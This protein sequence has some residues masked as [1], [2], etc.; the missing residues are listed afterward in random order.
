LVMR[1]VRLVLFIFWFIGLCSVCQCGCQ[2][3]G[4]GQRIDDVDRAVSVGV[5]YSDW[6]GDFLHFLN[7]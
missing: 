4:L 3:Q 6:F 1:M 2:Q 7:Q 5:R